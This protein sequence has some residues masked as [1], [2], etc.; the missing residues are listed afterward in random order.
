M[1]D[2]GILDILGL[3]ET[4]HS[5]S[6]AI[7]TSHKS[8]DVMPNINNDVKSNVKNEIPSHSTQNSNNN[9]KQI[10]IKNVTPNSTLIVEPSKIELMKK[11]VNSEEE[12][13]SFLLEPSTKRRMVTP[14]NEV[15]DIKTVIN[16]DK[17]PNESNIQQIPTQQK[18][19]VIF[20]EDSLPD[21]S[22]NASKNESKLA[23]NNIEK[24]QSMQI[25][26]KST[27]ESPRK[28]S[29]LDILVNKFNV[30]NDTCYFKSDGCE[31]SKYWCVERTFIRISIFCCNAK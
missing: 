19:S 8:L 2:D 29:I 25:S 10:L 21:L 24:K 3:M 16:K 20:N 5:T 6:K 23:N 17:K 31:C 7:G 13:P 18:K 9:H 28:L 1:H 26:F 12:L 14:I 15:A 4:K 22:F 27:N 30:E 11:N